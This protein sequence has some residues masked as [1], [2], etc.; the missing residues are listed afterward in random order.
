M[1]VLSSIEAL[2]AALA[3]A[4]AEGGRLGFVPTMGYLHRRTDGTCLAGPRWK[5][6]SSIRF[7]SARQRIS[8]DIRVI[9]TATGRCWRCRCRSSLPA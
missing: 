6:G 2:R 4:R 8:V 1:Q 7:S 3:G 9:W 5:R